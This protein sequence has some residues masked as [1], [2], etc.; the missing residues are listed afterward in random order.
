MQP[1]DRVLVK[2]FA[3]GE[4]WIYA[5]VVHPRD[6]GGALVVV[7]HPGNHE[8]GQMKNVKREELRTKA[9]LQPLLDEAR[10]FSNSEVVQG[11]GNERKRWV[12]HYEH[13]IEQLS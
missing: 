4:Q 13:Q 9:D 11:A 10:K 1:G 6:D 3:G 2:Q 12:A 7:E 5:S 8:H